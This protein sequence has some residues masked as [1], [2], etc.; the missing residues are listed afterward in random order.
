MYSNG[1]LGGAL[2]SVTNYLANTQNAIRGT[3]RE[4]EQTIVAKITSILSQ[5]S[6][7]DVVFFTRLHNHLSSNVSAS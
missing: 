6:S 7:R 1:F 4:D 2:R 5:K 3:S